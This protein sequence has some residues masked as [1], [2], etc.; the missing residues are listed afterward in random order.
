LS[1]KTG[2]SQ[3]SKSEKSS[4]SSKYRLG[5]ERRK[6]KGQLYEALATRGQAKLECRKGLSVLEKKSGETIPNMRGLGKEKSLNCLEKIQGQK[7]AQIHKKEG[8]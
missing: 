7:R 6:K 2:V 3:A 5:G 1:A 8:P 4:K